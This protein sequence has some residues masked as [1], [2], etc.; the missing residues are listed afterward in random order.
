MISFRNRSATYFTGNVASVSC[1]PSA[2]KISL[3][4][5]PALSMCAPSAASKPATWRV[6][7]TLQ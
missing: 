7:I 4:S 6:L 1:T 5:A 3:A 2:A